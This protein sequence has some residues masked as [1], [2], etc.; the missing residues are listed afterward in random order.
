MTLSTTNTRTNYPGAGSTGPFAIPYRILSSNQ[1]LVTRGFPG[2][3]TTLVLGTDYSVDT[4]LANVTLTTALAS[5]D[6]I[7]I[8]RK[9]ALD[10]P[11]SIRNQGAYFPATIEDE[12]DRLV[13]QIQSQQDQ[14]DRSLRLSE[15]FNPALYS[16]VLTDLT[17]G[18]VV[19][20]TGTGLTMSTLS[21]SSNVTLPGNGRTV[22][23]LSAY[24]ANNALWANAKDYG[25][26]FDG[27]SH[28]LSAFFNSVGAAQVTYPKALALTDE[29]DWAAS[30]KSVDALGPAGG[31]VTFPYGKG[32]FNR[33]LKW[34]DVNSVIL[35][36]QGTHTFSGVAKPTELNFSTL[37]TGLNAI[38]VLGTN[39]T[40]TLKRTQM[41]G[42]YLEMLNPS[43]QVGGAGVRL[44]N[45]SVADIDLDI[46]V[47]RGATSYAL[48]LGDFVS[49]AN[50]V[51]SS[52][53]H[54]VYVCNGTPILCG[55]G[56][57]S[58][59]FKTFSLQGSTAGIW[60][61]KCNYCKAQNCAS[62]SSAQPSGYGYRVDGCNSVTFDTCGAENIARAFVH[63]TGG[64]TAVSVE[65]CRGAG[66]NTD[67]LAIASFAEIDAVGGLCHSLYFKNCIDSAPNAATVFSIRGAATTGWTTIVGANTT[68]LPK[69]VGG[70]ATWLATYVTID[71][72]G[73]VRS[74]FRS[75]DIGTFAALA[76]NTPTTLFTPLRSGHYMVRASVPGAGN[77]EAVCLAAY[78]SGTVALMPGFTQTTDARIA[79]TLVGANITVTQTVGSPQV[80]N[81][82]Y[83]ILNP[84]T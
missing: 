73:T 65:N 52:E 67:A 18:K 5:G 25:A 70:D 56:S 78:H 64:S 3:E 31:K 43:A 26:V 15:A 80:V 1:L 19:T 74:A 8:R 4:A 7:T 53:I 41:R 33:T 21:S 2:A 48:Q 40:N 9:P 57:T 54:G 22:A 79:L 10:Q 12:F 38:E 47:T 50:A 58:C 84:L 29:L 13:M 36:G 20:G 69:G 83:T 82:S 68:S 77:I 81:W 6:Q 51:I 32:I 35:E 71:L 39:P 28:P 59:T 60:F 27:A 17:A 44:W 24:L 72:G 75:S 42:F 34:T 23:T 30:Q 55:V 63:I 16:M 11:A 45:G 14:L 46:Y 49:I 61:Y 66:N 76:N 37:P 62:D